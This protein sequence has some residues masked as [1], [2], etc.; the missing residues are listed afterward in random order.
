M[1]TILKILSSRTFWTIV[2]M[3]LLGG[4]QAV[5]KVVPAGFETPVMAFLGILAT[6][7]HVTP[8]QVY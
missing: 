7:F 4:V 3:F 2:L 5:S 8:S 1:A 6:Y